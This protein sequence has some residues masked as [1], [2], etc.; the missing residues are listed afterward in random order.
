MSEPFVPYLPENVRARTAGDSPFRVTV[1][2]KAAEAV[3]PFVPAAPMAK[4]AGPSGA[5]GASGMGNAAFGGADP[6]GASGGG[7]EPQLSLE[8]DG[9]RITRITVRCSCG[10]VIELNCAY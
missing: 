10:Q 8:R 9:D 1:L 2:P 6:H 4:S 5:T 3:A 7:H